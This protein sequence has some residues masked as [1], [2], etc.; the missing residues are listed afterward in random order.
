LTQ[1]LQSGKKVRRKR[2]LSWIP[3]LVTLPR[4]RKDTKGRDPAARNRAHRN[5]S[6]HTRGIINLPFEFS[7]PLAVHTKFLKKKKIMSENEFADMNA[8][9]N[10]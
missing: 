4:G 2:S 1:V 9:R 8:G 7:L 5:I 10:K 3:V 6:F